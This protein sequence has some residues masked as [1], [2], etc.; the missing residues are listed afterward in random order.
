MRI[1]QPAEW[2]KPKGYAH[3]V[4]AEG[5]S[6]HIAGQFGCNGQG[7]FES[8]DLAD[9][10]RQALRNIVRILAEA[11]AR[12]E[13][14]VRMTWYVTDL[15]EYRAAAER[16]GPAWRD[17]LGR[18]FPAITLVQVAGLLEPRAKVEIEAVA[19]IPSKA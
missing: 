10:V 16:I 14:I 8:D 11:G 17:L 13:H 18:H 2:A 4:L 19:V 15:A 9:Q 7:Q 5:Q 12:P 6:V 1:L 3:G